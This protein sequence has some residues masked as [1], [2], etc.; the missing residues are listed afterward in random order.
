MLG[1]LKRLLILIVTAAALTALAAAPAR[2]ELAWSADMQ[3]SVLD[4]SSRLILGAATDATDGFENAYETRAIIA[5]YL[6]AY[7]YHPEWGVDTPYFWTDI[8]SASLP[9]EWV[10]YVAC[11]YTNRNVSVRWTL[12]VPEG[13]ELYFTDDATGE[14]VVMT[15]TDSYQYLNTSTAV[16][17]FRVKAMGELPAAADET[18]PDTSITAAPA[19]FIASDSTEVS[20]T[21][22][23]DTT[24]AGLLEFS[25]DVDGGGWSAWSTNTT[26]APGGL[27]E[28]AHTFSVKARDAAGNEDPTPATRSF[29]VDLTPPALAAEAGGALPRPAAKTV[30][31]NVSGSATDA[32]SGVASL[33]YEVSDAGYAAAGS[34]TPD[35][36]G[37]FSFTL[38]IEGTI[39]DLV[40]QG[41][42][43]FDM[44]LTAVDAAGNGTTEVIPV[45]VQPRGR[46]R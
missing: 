9:N 23:D 34:V 15:G 36:A 32:L 29:T 13:L 4:D 10:F 20:Y 11:S 35:G 40:D 24:P 46:R 38:S 42:K 8:R 25:Y 7:F 14:V 21:G 12:D 41:G 28:G 27:A 16:R 33:G 1:M 5:G 6:S 39:G 30:D 2:A 45:L 44:T 22:T 18:A 26:A 19:E 31:I 17:T 43:L 37:N 3:L